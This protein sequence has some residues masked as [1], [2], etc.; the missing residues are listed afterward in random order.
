M[1]TVITRIICH[2]CLTEEY[3][4][5]SHH[6]TQNPS[7]RY[8]INEGEAITH[9]ECSICGATIEEMTLCH[10][11]SIGNV[12]TPKF[13]YSW[14][15]EYIIPTSKRNLRTEGRNKKKREV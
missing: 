7:D 14:Y 12:H 2:K 11:I 8:D 10:T 13:S 15:L 3:N 4:M 1:C 5:R 9:Y 6:L